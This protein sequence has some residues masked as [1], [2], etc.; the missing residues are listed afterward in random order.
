MASCDPPSCFFAIHGRCS[1]FEC[2]CSNTHLIKI[3]VVRAARFI[4]IHY[5]WRMP[6]IKFIL[7]VLFCICIFHF[8]AH[9]KLATNL[10][11]FNVTHSYFNVGVLLNVATCWVNFFYNM[12]F[13]IFQNRFLFLVQACIL[14]TIGLTFLYSINIIIIL[15]IKFNLL[16][17]I[18]SLY[19]VFLTHLWMH[20][21]YRSI[22]SNKCS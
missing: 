22:V 18:F 1:R 21:C 6:L 5:K 3:W 10:N 9:E 11:L 19:F 2:W 15:S 17:W 4:I 8:R 13:P 16:S 20:S 7:F 12:F 14:K